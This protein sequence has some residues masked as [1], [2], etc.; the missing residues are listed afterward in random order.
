[1]DNKLLMRPAIDPNAD[2]V[3]DSVTG[4]VTRDGEEYVTRT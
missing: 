1:V 2:V 4:V 3:W